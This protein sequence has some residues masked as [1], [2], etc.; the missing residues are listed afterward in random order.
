MKVIVAEQAGFC[1]GVKRALKIIDQ[2]SREG[3]GIQTFGYLIH[4]NSV[5][6][7]LQRKGIHSVSSSDD[8]DPAKM[9]V[10][11][12]HGIAKEIEAKLRRRHVVLADA[13]C[14]LVKKTHRIVERLS[15]QKRPLV[16]IGDPRHPEIIATQSY[17]RRAQVIN[18]LA[19]ARRLRRVPSLAVIAQTTLN[20]EFFERVLEILRRKT[21][22]L[23]V[24]DTIC[25]ATRVRQNAIR[26]LASRVDFVIVVGGKDSSNTKKLADIARRKNKR[27]FHVETDRELASVRFR[28]AIRPFRTVGIT[29]GASTP[30]ADVRKVKKFFEMHPTKGE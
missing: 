19:A 7:S 6:E 8:V 20:T 21:D 2:L 3:R 23:E 10:I 15:R 18:S 26:R 16:I 24:F 4:N 30:P 13:T 17:S 29:A 5:Q 25:Q 14:P 28:E 9:L 27:T 1:F 12:T 22:R 11:R